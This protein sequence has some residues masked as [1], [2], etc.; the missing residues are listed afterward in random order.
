MVHCVY[1]KL[2]RLSLVMVSCT[3]GGIPIA[4]GNS[5][6]MCCFGTENWV[7]LYCTVGG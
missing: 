5:L 2:L 4:T 6:L 7:E 3:V 1:C